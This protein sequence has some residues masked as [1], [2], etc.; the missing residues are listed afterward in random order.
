MN[1]ADEDGVTSLHIAGYNGHVEV[2]RELLNHGAKVD[3]SKEASQTFINLA[4]EKGY[5]D[6]IRGVLK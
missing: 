4:V 2:V 5:L 1:T 3:K 6:L